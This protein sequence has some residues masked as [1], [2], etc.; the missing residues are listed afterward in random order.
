MAPFLA[1]L[2]T[3]GNTMADL[4]SDTASPMDGQSGKSNNIQESSLSHKSSI[5]MKVDVPEEETAS[6]KNEGNKARCS[7]VTHSL[8][9]TKPIFGGSGK[10]G[11][12]VSAASRLSNVVFGSNPFAVKPATFGSVSNFSCA[13]SSQTPLG[14]SA[15]P[16]AVYLRP[17]QLALGSSEPPQQ[18]T[19]QCRLP[20]KP[21]SLA[22][23]FTRVPQDSVMTSSSDGVKAEDNSSFIS[24]EVGICGNS[25]SPEMH[26]TNSITETVRHEDDTKAAVESDSQQAD[27]DSS[28]SGSVSNCGSQ[29]SVRAIMTPPKF[30]P[31]G[32]PSHPTEESS[33]GNMACTS[34][35]STSTAT[36]SSAPTATVTGFV[37]GQNL[38][39]RV[40]EAVNLETT[41]V[42][43]KAAEATETSN[44]V[45][46]V[47]TSAATNGTSEMLFTSVIKKDHISE[48]S[49]NDNINTDDIGDKPSKSLT[50][51]AREYEEARAVKRKYEQVTIVTG[52][53]DEANVLQMNCK[54]FAFDKATGTWVELGRGTLRLNDKDGGSGGGGVQSRVVIRATG[55]LRV[56]LNT[57]IWAGMSVQRPS[58]KSVRLTAMDGSGQIK[59]FLV[60]SSPKESEQL[61]KSLEYRVLLAQ[62]ASSLQTEAEASHSLP[63]EPCSKKR[64]SQYAEETGPSPG[65]APV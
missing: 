1:K 30:V 45:S 15:S 2:S 31:L 55:S 10:L 44:N 24:E 23:T 62:Q 53:E 46:A 14:S 18:R 7:T 63:P 40:V 19:F 35:T 51:A 22:N 4:R 64:P 21:P 36:T 25:N 28:N 65:V 61:H 56:V 58:S 39:E 8:S 29:R 13:T 9:S 47:C 6:C 33:C 16:R 60:M 41:D 12:S 34:A 17:S 42:A 43:S 20:L 49:H 37:F 32:T 57:K 11:S 5:M 54:L 52:E 59:V 50:E 3:I 27:E 26:S 38:H 48:G